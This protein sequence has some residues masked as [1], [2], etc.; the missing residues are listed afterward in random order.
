MDLLHFG[1][2]GAGKGT[3]A[4]RL[5][6]ELGYMQLATG[7]M[8]RAERSSGS[9]LEKKFDEF[10]SKGLLV[11]D[12][13]VFELLEKGLADPAAKEGVIF[14]GFPRTI[15]QAKVLDEVLTRHGRSIHKV[16]SMEV[17]LSDILDR[18][19]GRRVCQSCGQ[20]YH[21]RYN[22]PPSDGRCGACG[23]SSVIQRKDDAEDVVTKRYEEYKTKTE[24]M[25]GYY[26]AKGL[27]ASVNGVGP[28]DEV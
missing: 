20:V 17:P 22:P 24:P 4:K 16:V 15:P 6:E 13:L 12:E 14:D 2:P 3:Q 25:L 27:V 8:M 21:V 1:P 11:P 9:E 7:D 5:V 18:V 26:Q 28:L 19:G 10:M 23:G